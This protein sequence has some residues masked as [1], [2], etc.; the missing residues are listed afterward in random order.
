MTRSWL[1]RC[2]AVKP[3]WLGTLLLLC[4][5]VAAALD[6]SR[7]ITQYRSDRWTRREGLPQ[8]SVLCVLQ[9]RTGYLWL[10]LQEGLARFDG[11][12]FRTFKVEDTPA[13]ASNYV[14]ALFEDRNGRIWI[15]TDTGDL[16]YF[17]G[18]TLVAVPLGKT[19]RGLV[20]GFAERPG[21]D[22]F[23][24]FRGAGLQRLAGDRLEPVT[25]Q[26]GRPIDNLGSM[27]KG[28]NGEIWAGGEGKLF[29]FLRGGWT[30]FDLPGTSGRPVTALAVHPGGDLLYS[31]DDQAVRRVRPKGLSLEPVQPDRQLPAPVLALFFDRDRTLWI[32]TGSGVARW[33][34]D[35]GAGIE[36]WPAGPRSS[37]A[38]FFEDREGGL[39]IGTNLE[40]LLRLR[41]DEVV[42]LGPAEGLPDDKT[43]NVM[44][45]SDGALWVTTDGGLTRIAGGRI[46]RISLPGLPSGDGV[47]LG[48]RRD[49]SVWVGTFRS[50]LFRLP[51]DGEPLLRFTAAE[52][53]AAGPVTVVFEDSRGK[54]WVGSREGLARESGARLGETR[55]GEDSFEGVR[56]VEGD[57][58][59]YIGSIVEDREGTVWIATTAGL[60]AQSASGMRRYGHGDGLASTALNALLLDR[61]GR[62]WIAT[63]GHGIQVLDGGRFLT[64]DR[65]H[66]LPT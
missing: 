29:R 2:L 15:G 40:G 45:T 17:D 41:A 5:I 61:D 36:P 65:R 54:L 47:A 52:G 56:L 60:F 38:D 8:M 25:D 18:E 42:L 48:E 14:S 12:S 55:L 13:L 62:L 34:A 4:P 57:V 58:Q 26:D 64:I 50:G 59:P 44:E 1:A 20:V 21:G 43:W 7:A 3:G 28:R 6:P 11:I 32:G 23:V 9:D 35:P 16:S 33:R 37:V 53:L 19:L 49:G 22:L 51:R 24:G 39:W 46:E 66:G 10:G 31:E 30:R 63:N 27:T